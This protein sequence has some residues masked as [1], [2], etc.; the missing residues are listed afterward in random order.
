MACP[1]QGRGQPS[2]E[3][4]GKGPESSAGKEGSAL[5]ANRERVSRLVEIRSGGDGAVGTIGD[6]GQ[7]R[8]SVEGRVVRKRGRIVVGDRL[9]V[10]GRFQVSVFRFQARKFFSDT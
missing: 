5:P 4:C 2:Q 8:T 10:K 9:T 7:K 6:K 3:L 1:G